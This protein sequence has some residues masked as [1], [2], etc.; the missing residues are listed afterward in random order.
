MSKYGGENRNIPNLTIPTV[1]VT[2]EDEED[3]PPLTINEFA[4]PMNR[5]MN[6][7]SYVK[8]DDVASTAPLLDSG[9]ATPLGE[10]PAVPL[11][12]LETFLRGNQKLNPDLNMEEIGLSTFDDGKKN[13]I[14]GKAKINLPKYSMVNWQWNIIRNTFSFVLYAAMLGAFTVSAILVAYLPRRCDPDFEWWQGKV[15]YEVFPASFYDSDNS[16][17]GDLN[18][19]ALKLDYLKETLNVDALHLNSICEAVD[20]PHSY[21]DIVNCTRVDPRIGDMKNFQDL[22]AGVDKRNMSL[23]L[24]LHIDRLPGISGASTL[25]EEANSVVET[26]IKFWLGQG[27]HGFF[28]KGLDKFVQ[29]KDLAKK[30]AQ[31]KEMINK[32]NGG[33]TKPRILITS[34][35]FLVLYSQNH[36]QVKE[37][38]NEFDLV[39]YNL[40]AE[41]IDTLGDQIKQGLRW[42]DAMDAPWILWSLNDVDDTGKRQCSGNMAAL[43]LALS[44]PGSVSIQYGHEIGLRSSHN[45]SFRVDMKF[46]G[47]GDT[48]CYNSS[49]KTLGEM[50]TIRRDAVPIHNNVIVKYDAKGVLESRFF[51]YAYNLLSNRTVVIERSY[52]R[53]HRYL[54]LVNLS[55]HSVTNDLSSVY[56]GGLTL[57]SSTG[58][59][60]DYIQ[61]K[62]VNM[63]PGEGLL[64]LLDR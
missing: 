47:E 2:S 17:M 31:W 6:Q 34:S 48:G 3:S 64:L 61:L 49:T 5:Q 45:S 42:N 35:D 15:F 52:P 26:T 24:D 54:L 7:L 40:H 29:Q 20:Y 50:A 58:D 37:I 19:L 46:D 12:Q 43:M 18:G 32:F 10:E 36:P 11:S 39:D 22:V 8:D 51:N 21:L 59:K 4:I 27:V 14:S 13:D 63:A 53:R 62:D 9:M 33:F 1:F 23:V 55:G 16:G 38:Q 56:F 30:V 44:L 28:L 60:R 25:S 41:H 57:V